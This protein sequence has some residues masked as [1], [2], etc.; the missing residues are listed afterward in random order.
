VR[1]QDEFDRLDMLA[2]IRAQAEATCEQVRMFVERVVEPF[3]EV[4]RKW[5]SRFLEG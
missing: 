5:L 3:G 4:A 1:D 2:D